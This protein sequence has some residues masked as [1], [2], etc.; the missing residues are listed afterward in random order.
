MMNI[1]PPIIATL[2]AAVP[3]VVLALAVLYWGHRRRN[4]KHA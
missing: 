3:L 4:R 1:P 2:F